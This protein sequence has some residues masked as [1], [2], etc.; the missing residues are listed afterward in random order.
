MSLPT[1]RQKVECFLNPRHFLNTTNVHLPANLR[2][3]VIWVPK[4]SA[5]A[6]ATTAT[7][8]SRGSGNGGNGGNGGDD[9]DDDDADDGGGGEFAVF[10][11]QTAVAGTFVSTA[12]CVCVRARVPACACVCVRA[13][14]HACVSVRLFSMHYTFRFLQCCCFCCCCC[15]RY[16]FRPQ[17]LGPVERAEHVPPLRLQNRGER[18]G[19]TWRGAARPGVA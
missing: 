2:P 11:A 4:E 16:R 3:E 18:L 14:V 15:C 19:L 5:A 8:A 12:D 10:D 13:R 1:E 9:D 17:V 7:V 6:I